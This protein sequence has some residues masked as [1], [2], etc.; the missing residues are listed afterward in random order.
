MPGL[1]EADGD[2]SERDEAEEEEDEVAPVSALDGFEERE[3]ARPHIRFKT[4]AQVTMVV[5]QFGVTQKRTLRFSN[6]DRFEGDFD[7]THARC[8]LPLLMHQH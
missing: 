5:N 1:Y 3:R 4:A 8:E 6:G 2:G 7:M